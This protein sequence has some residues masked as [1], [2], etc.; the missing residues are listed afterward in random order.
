[1]G[2]FAGYYG[3]RVVPP[4]RREEFSARVL[5][6]LQ[7]GGM[8]RIEPIN[9]YDKSIYLLSPL[10]A[11]EKGDI[12]FSYN[13]FENSFWETAGY[14]VNEAIFF[15][16]KI[17]WGIFHTVVCAVYVLYEFY[18]STFG[19]AEVDG[20]IFDA[21][22]IIRWFN[23]LFGEKYTNQRVSDL[24]RIYRLLHDYDWAPDQEIA[25][26]LIPQNPTGTINQAGFNSYLAVKFF[27]HFKQEAYK[28][29][30]FQNPPE[31]GEISITDRIA[32]SY[33]C[34]RTY[35]QDGNET[36]EEKIDWLQSLLAQRP[37]D[38][39]APVIHGD[40]NDIHNK[41]RFWLA[42]NTPVASLRMIADVFGF[43][44]WD[45]LKKLEITF[46]RT[47]E[48]F[49]TPDECPVLPPLST[50]DFLG[51]SDDERAY[52]W[53]PDGNITFSQDMTDLLGHLRQRLDAIQS[54]EGLLLPQGSL[55]RR[56]IEILSEADQVYNGIYAF[57]E[58][59]YDFLE[60]PNDR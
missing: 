31:D 60:Y 4:E 27:D 16:N 54:Q 9:L 46:P 17:G 58:T 22:K 49:P 55:I 33:R 2:T 15:S 10:K 18:S 13:Y 23:H 36:G 34:L 1:M 48:M 35:Q 26:D 53:T 56:L 11:N 14:N 8:M 40:S 24:W 51:R 32:R 38:I 25:V 29:S 59:F 5:T 19:I 28:E 7:E 42:M 52:F 30:E 6:I 43:D 12:L 47:H 41:L 39:M 3:D 45:R 37:L 50:G 21:R 20:R 44:F 57:Q